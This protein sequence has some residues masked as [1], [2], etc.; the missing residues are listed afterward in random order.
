MRRW[1][2][3]RT[4][5]GHATNPPVGG[6]YY[7]C[8]DRG[9]TAE[10]FHAKV[11]FSEDV[12]FYSV[13]SSQSGIDHTNF[14]KDAHGGQLLTHTISALNPPPGAH[15]FIDPLAPLFITGNQN[16]ARDVAASM[17]GLSRIIEERQINITGICHFSKQKGNK[18]DRYARP[19]DRI[20]GSG[21][22]SGF[23][24]TQIYLVDPELPL[25]P[26]YLLGWNPRHHKPEEFR[27]TREEWFVPYRGLCDVGTAADNDRPTFV[28]SYIPDD[29]I[30]TGDLVDIAA[31][32]LDCSPRTIFSDIKTLH[33][34]GSIVKDEQ[35]QKLYRRPLN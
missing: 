17:V 9:Q 29:G 16:R 28:L 27:C 12:H 21:A 5:W 3:G 7:V 2:D 30:R 25:Q 34:R 10:A 20:S 15:L 24:D 33:E 18:N 35:T 6:F 22:F 14:H 11:G 23:S 8:A 31:D 4:I 32:R 26:Y 19:Q 13:V 1:R